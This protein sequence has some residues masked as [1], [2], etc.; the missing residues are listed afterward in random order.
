[1]KTKNVYVYLVRFADGTLESMSSPSLSIAK[2]E[3]K[4]DTDYLGFSCS[5]IV[6]VAAP[7]P[8]VKP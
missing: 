6:K 8:E 1:V 2:A 7:I 3:R 5:P 4:H